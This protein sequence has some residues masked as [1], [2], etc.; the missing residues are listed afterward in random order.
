MPGAGSLTVAP[1][2]SVAAGA[3]AQRGAAADPQQL[4]R[5]SYVGNNPITGTDPSGHCIGPVLVWCV[6]V[7]GE[8]I[9]DVVVPAVI[10]SVAIGVAAEAGQQLGQ[11][12]AA[13]E[14]AS[15][16]VE[17]SEQPE[18]QNTKPDLTD[19]RAKRHILDGDG[20]GGGH[21]AGT[22]KPGK[23]EFPK[24]W[25]DAKIWVRYRMWL[26]ILKH[27]TMLIQEQVVLFR[28]ALGVV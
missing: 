21:K 19:D 3:W 8:F 15:E 23:S 22:G 26:P 11:A 10:G 4:N 9:A 18:S 28:R 1:S 25:S 5:Y 16:G 24:D 2:D 14:Q 20:T 7:V 6:V 17:T 27:S 13:A 12:H